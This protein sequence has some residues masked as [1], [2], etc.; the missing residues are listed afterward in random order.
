VKSAGSVL[1]SSALY[2][3]TGLGTTVEIVVTEPRALVAAASILNGQVEW[4]DQVASRFREDSQISMLNAR[5]GFPVPVSEE[6]YELIDVA[7]AMADATDGTVDLTVGAAMIELG[8]DRDFKLIDQAAV[9]RPP[10]LRPVPGWRSLELD[11]DTRTVRAPE[12]TLI[13]LGAT[14]KAWAADRTARLAATSLGCGVLVSLG[15]DIAVAG[16]PPAGGFA[17]GVA[18]KCG[19]LTASETV[20]ISSGGLATSGTSARRWQRGSHLVHHIVDPTSGRCSDSPWRTVSVAAA[21]CLA[22]NAASTAA[23]VKGVGA[24]SWLS[25]LGLPARLVG[26]DGLV[27]RTL[28]W[29]PEDTAVVSGRD[30]SR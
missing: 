22:A 30:A 16:D 14:A 2:R 12:G 6:L 21:S 24:P 19:D 1:P 3:N 9:G 23:V 25:S 13:D 15:G 10:S 11:A 27:L 29:P 17:V 7:V 20:A 8:Y 18:D 26:L 5:S 28:G 4:I